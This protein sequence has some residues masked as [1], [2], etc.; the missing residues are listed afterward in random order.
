MLQQD[1]YHCAEPLK[2]LTILNPLTIDGSDR[3]V[4][5]VQSRPKQTQSL[6]VKSSADRPRAPN[7]SAQTLTQL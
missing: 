3:R 2:H 7:M 5:L 1:A 6:A 4:L